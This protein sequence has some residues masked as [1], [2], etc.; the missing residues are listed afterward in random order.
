MCS[1]NLH[2]GKQG[3]KNKN[4]RKQTENEQKNGRLDH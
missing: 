3:G 2:K 1:S 4:Q